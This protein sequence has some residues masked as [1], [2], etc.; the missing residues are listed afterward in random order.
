M[1]R[2]LVDEAADILADSF[3]DRDVEAG[4]GWH[5]KEGA[6]L[7][8]GGGFVAVEADFAGAGDDFHALRLVGAEVEAA[9]IDE[10]KGLL[11]AAGEDDGVAYDFAIKV[12]IGFGD[13]GDI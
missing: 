4:F 3:G 10:A 7:E 1:G 5:F 11:G 9:G 12:N 6:S 2:I 13:G 8:F